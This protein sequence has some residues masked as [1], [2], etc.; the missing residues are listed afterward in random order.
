MSKNLG[1]SQGRPIILLG[2]GG[3][4]KVLLSL[5]RV[6]NLPIQ[7][8]CAPELEKQGMSSWRGVDVLNEDIILNEFNMDVVTLVNGVGHLPGEK[9]RQRLFDKFK[10]KE[11]FFQKL[12]HPQA[13][14]DQTAS[15]DEG[16]QVMAGAVIQADTC[17]GKNVMIDTHASIDHDC[18]IDEHVHIAPGAVLCGN[19]RVGKRAFIGSGAVLTQGIT[20][21]EA[22]CIG[23]GASIVRDVS[24]RQLVLPAAVR[25]QYVM[26]VTTEEDLMN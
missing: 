26:M 9:N 14:V 15:L 22:A 2:A 16:A 5:I 25:R 13:Y 20:V 10:N 8:V 18:I 17:V 21:G 4:A 3:H 19:V 7:G 6:M 1:A 12:I 24:S 11:Y 23:A